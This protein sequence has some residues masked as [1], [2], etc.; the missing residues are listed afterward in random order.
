MISK[1]VIPAYLPDKQFTK[2]L[3]QLAVSSHVV[4]STC[5]KYGLF[6]SKIKWLVSEFFKQNNSLRKSR[7]F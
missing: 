2:A 5:E 6:F 3:V 7:D 1:I 4:M